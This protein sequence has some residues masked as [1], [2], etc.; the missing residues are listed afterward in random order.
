MTTTLGRLDPLVTWSHEVTWLIKNDISSCPRGLWQPKLTRSR[1]IVK[2]HHPLSLLMLWS[3]DQVITWQ[4]ENV[5]SQLPRGLWLPNLTEWWVLMLAIKPLS[6]KSHNLLITWSYKVTWQMK[7]VIN[8]L[9]RDLLLSN[10]AE[11]WLMIRSHMSNHKATYSFD[12][13]VTWVH[14]TNEL[15]YIFTYTMPIATKLNRV[16]ACNEESPLKK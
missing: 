13:V 8:S 1:F 5:I 9:S 7:N 12:H 2:G 3:G 4:M 6:I 10:L 11:G 15:R 16:M 14:V